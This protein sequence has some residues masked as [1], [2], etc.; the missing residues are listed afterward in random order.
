[1]TLLEVLVSVAIVSMIGTVLYGAFH[2]MSRSRRGMEEVCDRHHQGRAALSRMARELSSA[3]I[4][5]HIPFGTTSATVEP[6]QTAFI[7]SDSR[8]AD[9]VDFTSFSH[10]RLRADAHESDQCELSYFASRN[11]E[12]NGIDLVRRESRYIDADATKGGVVQ[13]LA[14]NIESFELRYLDPQTDEWV[15]SWDTTQAAGQLGR[16]PS[17]V[18]ISLVLTTGEDSPPARF[19]TKVVLPIRLPLEFAN[20]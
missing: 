5:L 4:S 15:D 16:L 18:W 14:E 8:P 17:Q 7:G 13:V 10:R 1:M 11:P 2:G 12:T 19:D 3:F 9:R 6:P 20:R